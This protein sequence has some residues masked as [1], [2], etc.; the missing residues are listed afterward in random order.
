M[1]NTATTRFINRF[2]NADVRDL[3][4]RA[5][6]FPDVDMPF[7][8]EQ[9]AGRQK[10]HTKLPSWAAVEGIVYPPHISMEQCSSE[11]VARYKGELAV[12]L[13][14]NRETPKGRKYDFVDLTGGFGVDFSFIAKSLKNSNL[15]DDFRACYVERQQHLCGVA[16]HN[17]GLLGLTYA[18][19]TCGDGIAFLHGME[20]AGIIYLDPARR[21]LQ[22]SKTYAI[23]DCMPNVLQIDDE[24]VTKAGYVLVKLS[25]MLDWHK[26]VADLKHVS[27]VHIVSVNNECKELLLVLQ[28]VVAGDVHVFC[29]NDNDVFDYLYRSDGRNAVPVLSAPLA[30]GMWLYEPNASIMKA[31]CFA[32][33]CLA[34]AL[35][36][37]SHN[38]HLFVSTDKLSGFPGRSFRILSVSSINRKDL[39]HALNGISYAN[40]AVRNFPMSVAELRKRLKLKDG[41]D[42]Y[43]F[44]TTDATGN[45]L[46]LICKKSD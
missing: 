27:E 33:L 23:E 30:E 43:I 14:G 46:L 17:F 40:I 41:G 39:H 34:Y 31:G 24:L 29:V 25:P 3:A 20:S 7:A 45:H 32:Q 44:A 35:K 15:F 16:S 10:A 12:R 28:R 38:S 8:L 6:R 11:Q 36:S 37:V 26:A 42:I 19:V 22:G 1:T 18:D 9:I 2:A 5:A 4:L 13:C 21:N